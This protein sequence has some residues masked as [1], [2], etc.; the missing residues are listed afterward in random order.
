MYHRYWRHMAMTVML[1]AS[2]KLPGLAAQSVSPLP[3]NPDSLVV[4]LQWGPYT[5]A[6][7][8]GT[9]HEIRWVWNG[10]VV[11]LDTVVFPA[12][13]ITVPVPAPE[14]PDT[15]V[16]ALWSPAGGPPTLRRLKILDAHKLADPE[17]GVWPTRLVLDSRSRYRSPTT[18]PVEPAE[19]AVAM[20][21]DDPSQL[22]LDCGGDPCSFP[23]RPW[24]K[25]EYVL[26]GGV[27]GTG[28]MRMHWQT[29]MAVEYS[30]VW[31]HAP[32]VRHFKI[33]YKVRQSSFMR[34]LGSA[35]KLLR[36]RSGDYIVGTL[37]SKQGEFVWFWDSWYEGRVSPA[38][39][40]GRRVFADDLWHTYE[41]EVDYRNIRSLR[42]RFW[43]DGVPTRP[44]RRSATTD[45]MADTLIISPFVEMYS[46]G[47]PNCGRSVNTGDYVVDDFSLTPLP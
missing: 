34:H 37:E 38:T 25:H 44:V 4:V 20:D 47:P 5:T 9:P 2:T 26:T 30:P 17:N 35:I 33:R 27:E 16:V 39:P 10:R 13:S 18:S 6:V 19:A 36:I 46:C 8:E 32:F 24:R 7:T 28:A 14:R 23:D 1:A 45:W 29:G 3:S 12:D 40:L 41:I 42:V 21:F 31:I 11:R 15:L 22:E 43:F